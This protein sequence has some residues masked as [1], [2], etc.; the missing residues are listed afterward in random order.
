MITTAIVTPWLR[1]LVPYIAADDSA[2]IF[3]LVCARKALARSQR[4][5]TT[6]SAPWVL[7]VSMPVRLST[8]VALRCAPAR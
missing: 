2:R 7:L 4:A 5:C 3:T 8:S 6:L 1:K